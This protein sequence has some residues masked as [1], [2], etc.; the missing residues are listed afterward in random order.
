LQKTPFWLQKALKIFWLQKKPIWLQ[1]ALILVAEKPFL[2]KNY[3]QS[4]AMIRMR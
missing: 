1:K 3:A 4:F 2:D